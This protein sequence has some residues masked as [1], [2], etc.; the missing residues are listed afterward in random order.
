MRKLKIKGQLQLNKMQVA[1]LDQ[2]QMASI[3][4]GGTYPGCNGGTGSGNSQPQT[5]CGG[6]SCG[7]KTCGAECNP[8]L[9]SRPPVC[10]TFKTLAGQTDCHSCICRW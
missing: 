6:I 4:G 1:T 2:S 10:P 7:P 5:Q 8:N 9:D 3:E